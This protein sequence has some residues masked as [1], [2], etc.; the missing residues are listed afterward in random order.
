MTFHSRVEKCGGC[1]HRSR[2]LSLAPTASHRLSQSKPKVSPHEPIAFLSWAYFWPITFLSWAYFWPITFLSWAYFW[3]IAF[4]SWAYFWPIAFLSCG[5]FDQSHS[6]L[7]CLLLTNRVPLSCGLLL[8]NRV[9][10]SC[11]L[12][13]TNRVPL[14][15]GLLL[16]NRVPLS[17]GLL[18]TNR[19]RPLLLSSLKKVSLLY[20]LLSSLLIITHN[21]FIHSAC[22]CFGKWNVPIKLSNV[23][24]TFCSVPVNL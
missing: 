7:V 6:S 22:V 4:L 1:G 10:L 23:L 11:G 24:H 21:L 16:T 15:C 14:S 18:L 20:R 8:T 12:L 9:P 13:L 3:P 2:Y 17:C 5:Y 19:R